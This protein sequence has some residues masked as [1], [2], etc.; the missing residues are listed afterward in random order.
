[1]NWNGKIIGFMLGFLGGP[2]GIVIGLI[3]GHLYDKGIFNPWLGRFGSNQA[4]PGHYSQV[5]K[6]F[7]DSNLLHYGLYSQIR[8]TH[9]GA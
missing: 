2:P 3:I 5:Q 4:Q 7:F 8:W 6:L 9:F 1:M